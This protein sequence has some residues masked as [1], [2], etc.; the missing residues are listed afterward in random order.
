MNRTVVFYQ[1]ND[2]SVFDLGSI[3]WTGKICMNP[4]FSVIF[5]ARNDFSQYPVFPWVIADYNSPYLNL[6]DC[7]G[8]SQESN[9]M[10]YLGFHGKPQSQIQ[11]LVI[12][13]G[14]SPFVSYIPLFRWSTSNLHCF[15]SL[16]SCFTS[17]FAAKAQVPIHDVCCSWWD[18]ISCQS[19]QALFAVECWIL[20]CLVK[21]L[22]FSSYSSR[23]LVLDHF[24]V[25][26]NRWNQ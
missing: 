3:V 9:F 15:L 25:A 18:P 8:P 17:F 10:G 26:K 24:S 12:F 22:I 20:I 19:S 16:N 4:T 5:H 14:K 7:R 23:F 2:Y 13:G 1:K 6:E 11:T 21:S